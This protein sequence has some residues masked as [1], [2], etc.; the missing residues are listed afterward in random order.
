M[1]ESPRLLGLLVKTERAKK[2]INDLYSAI[3]TFCE[4]DPY[5]VII[6]DD[7]QT[8]DRVF[9]VRES[10]AVPAVISAMLGDA[11][12]NLRSVLD[13]LAW[14][15][16]LANHDTPGN[17]T[18]YPIFESVEKYESHKAGKVKGMSDVAVEM[19]DATK[20][21]Q[22]GTDDL[23]R[24]HRLDNI[25]KHRLLI[26][27]GVVCPEMAID[28]TA[29][30]RHAYPDQPDIQLPR[31]PISTQ[32]GWRV[33]QDGAE[34]HRVPRFAEN[35]DVHTKPEFP[36]DIAVN[37]TEIGGTE[38]V[39]KLLNKFTHLVDGIVSNFFHLL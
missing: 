19:I 33:V 28:F 35:P 34:I 25:D 7:P 15:L 39:V 31:I 26:T 36:A 1:S 14:Q 27:I 3:R 18:A 17:W 13:Y 24:L 4:S 38:A 5:P 10:R 30:A 20:P 2:H 32:S 29:L 21:Y 12:H 37:E 6:E 16:V 9:R 22:G 8:G 11:I 23:W